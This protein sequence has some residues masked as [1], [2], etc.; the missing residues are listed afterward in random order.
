[1]QLHGTALLYR[2]GNSILVRQNA[3]VLTPKYSHFGI[4]QYKDIL[5]PKCKQFFAKMQVL[6]CRQ[7]CRLFHAKLQVF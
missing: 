6:W 5:M 7:K 4:N 3:V 2:I 1:M